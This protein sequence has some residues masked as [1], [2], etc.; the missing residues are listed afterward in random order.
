MTCMN[1]LKIIYL[2]NSF[3]RYTKTELIKLNNR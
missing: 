1:G 2:P 3:Y